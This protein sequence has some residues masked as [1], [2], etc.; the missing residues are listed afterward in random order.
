MLDRKRQRECA[1]HSNELEQ[2]YLVVREEK[3]E[4]WLEIRLKEAGTQ[5]NHK[6]GNVVPQ[7]DGETKEDSMMTGDSDIKQETWEVL[8]TITEMVQQQELELDKLIKSI[9]LFVIEQ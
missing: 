5:S 2:Q 9:Y 7:E 3:K 6:E 4:Q 1:Q 8:K